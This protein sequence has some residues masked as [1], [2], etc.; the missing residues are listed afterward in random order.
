MIYVVKKRNKNNEFLLRVF[1]KISK[2]FGCMNKVKERRYHERG[3]TKIRV[4]QEAIKRTY[5]RELAFANMI[6]S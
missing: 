1:K 2:K 5:Y 4:R 3:K 6:I